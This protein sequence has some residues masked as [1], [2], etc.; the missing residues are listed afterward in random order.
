MMR[1]QQNLKKSQM[2]LFLK[3]LSSFFLVWFGLVPICSMKRFF[4]DPNEMFLTSCCLA[5]SV[6][7]L[8]FY[9]EL[10]IT[11]SAFILLL[12]LHRSQQPW[13]HT[14]T[15]K[16]THVYRLRQPQVVCT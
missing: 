1:L 8:K 15:H 6:K 13:T 16:Y 7:L 11:A 4:V 2:L 12:P 9:C 3:S 10:G 14:N 5:L